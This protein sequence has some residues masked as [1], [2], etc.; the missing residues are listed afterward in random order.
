MTE[1]EATEQPFLDE[2][3]EKFFPDMQLSWSVR[4]SAAMRSP[5]EKLGL[6]SRLGL[7][8][9]MLFT[10]NS[11]MVKIKVE[12]TKKKYLNT[13]KLAF[14]IETNFGRPALDKIIADRIPDMYYEPSRLHE[15]LLELPWQDVFTTNYDTLLERASRKVLERK[16]SFILNADDL[17]YAEKPDH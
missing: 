10:K 16:Y 1:I 6:N 15:R 2:I 3:A 8:W 13:L 9:A 14:Q 4:A 7:N 17:I 5:M 12:S 11:M